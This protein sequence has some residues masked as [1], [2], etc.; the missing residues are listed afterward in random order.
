MGKLL[1]G[2]LQFLG[3]EIGRPRIEVAP[4]CAG[5]LPCP[6]WARPALLVEAGIEQI[7]ERQVG[8][9]VGPLPLCVFGPLG[10]LWR[11][12]RFAR[13]SLLLERNVAQER[14]APDRESPA[15][16][17]QTEDDRNEGK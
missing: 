10:P 11:S 8:I 9:A 16:P 6:I 1:H 17:P 12:K 13:S 5:A 14:A 7:V 4:R 15:I 2:A 3:A